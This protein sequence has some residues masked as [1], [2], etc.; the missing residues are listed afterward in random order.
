MADSPSWNVALAVAR[1]IAPLMSLLNTALI[2]LI[3]WVIQ[4]PQVK[5]ALVEAQ[6]ARASHQNTLLEPRMKLFRHVVQLAHTATQCQSDK[7]GRILKASL[8]KW[9]RLSLEGRFLL[10][11]NDL[12]YCWD[13]A[14]AAQAIQ[15]GGANA[16]QQL[17]WLDQQVRAGKIVDT[18]EKYF[19]ALRTDG[20]RIEN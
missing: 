3:F 7:R 10:N 9:Y 19:D 11:E 18:F 13:I 8:N 17:V 12:A 5:A 15:V 2:V 20:V 4:R 14:R 1:D 16:T 6:V